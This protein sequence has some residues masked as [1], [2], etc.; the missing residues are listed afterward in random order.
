MNFK[1]CHIALAFLLVLLPTQISSQDNLLPSRPGGLLAPSGGLVNGHAVGPLDETAQLK[2][3]ADGIERFVNG[4]TG[5]SVLSEE[6]QQ[7]SGGFVNGPTSTSVEA[8]E[9][10]QRADGGGALVEEVQRGQ[11]G[12]FVNGPTAT[13]V[14]LEE[15]QRRPEEAR[16]VVNGPTGISV[17][18]EENQQRLDG[19]L[20]ILS[21]ASAQKNRGR[22]S[23]NPEEAEVNKQMPA[24]LYEDTTDWSKDS[25]HWNFKVGEWS[26]VHLPDRKD[27]P[28]L[29]AHEIPGPSLVVVT[30]DVLK[31]VFVRRTVEGLS[32]ANLHYRY[33]LSIGEYP[34]GI[35]SLK[36]YLV[37]GDTSTL[38]ADEVS[39]GVWSDNTIPLDVSGTFQ[40]VFE[41]RLMKEGNEIAVDDITI[42]GIGTGEGKALAAGSDDQQEESETDSSGTQ[43]DEAGE[44]AVEGT[45]EDI[46]A[47]LTDT[48]N[49][50]T[51]AGNET[52]QE[53][54]PGAETN[55]EVPQNVTEDAES[56]GG[57]TEAPAVVTGDSEVGSNATDIPIDLP[58]VTEGEGLNQGSASPTSGD[59]AVLAG[60]D[61]TSST[62][63]MFK[64]FVVIC[65]LGAVALGFLYW[66]KRRQQDDEI[67]VFTRSS[68]ADYHNP[69]FSPD[70]DS[71]FAS[72]GTRH[73]YKSF[74]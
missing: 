4:P 22:I 39:R 24:G 45:E 62:W 47:N 7:E 10:R 26:L 23:T 35:P 8:E 31:K 18:A 71:S 49:G 59:V 58:E 21:A 61:A 57:V 19:D 12:P 30:E 11:E 36:V 25:K 53:S 6:R 2:V 52:G 60:D 44:E 51:G 3:R 74:D 41:G 64:I 9:N 55:T 17:E 34:H 29:P 5:T 20:G 54:V 66:R 16:V 63:G 70:D 40:I 1:T 72:Q 14:A 73:N 38:L 48:G 15:E 37:Q 42:S 68:H 27:H 28:D 56:Q 33:F 50:T 69:T 67:P 13:S 46:V 65:V 32:K 43:R